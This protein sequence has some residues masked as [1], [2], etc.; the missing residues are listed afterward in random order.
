MGSQQAYRNYSGNG[1]VKGKGIF[2]GQE[3]SL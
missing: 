2:T 1:Q 3:Q